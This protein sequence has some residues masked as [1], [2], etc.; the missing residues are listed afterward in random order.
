MN[1]WRKERRTV[2][3]E[4]DGRAPELTAL[5]TDSDTPPALRP[6]FTLPAGHR[7]DRVPGVTLLGDAAHLRAPNGRGAPAAGTPAVKP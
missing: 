5:I 2:A 7:W 3:K 4:F 6:I 1:P